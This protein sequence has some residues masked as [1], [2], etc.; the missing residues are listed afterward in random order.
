MNTL[1]H[2]NSHRLSQTAVLAPLLWFA[3]GIAIGFFF[4]PFNDSEPA[5][6]QTPPSQ[7]TATPAKSANPSSV[8]VP[9][10]L[11]VIDQLRALT[12]GGKRFDFAEALLLV[13]Q[14]PA[15]DCKTALALLRSAHGEFQ[16]P[17]FDALARRWADLDPYEAFS[18][19]ERERNN[20]IRNRLG[21]A[22]GAVLAERDP[23]AALDRIT[24]ARG[25]W[26]REK[27]AEWI[28]PAMAKTD[29][30][31]AAAYL[32]SN[33]LLT[34]HEHIYRDLAQAYGRSSP[35]GAII[36]AESLS[37]ERLRDQCTQKAWHGWL[38]TDPATFAVEINGW[39]NSVKRAQIAPLVSRHWSRAD[40]F[41]ALAW[42]ETVTD[43]RAREEASG[44]FEL[45]LQKIG[46]DGARKILGTIPSEN[47][48]IH[49]GRVTA[50]QLARDSV[51]EA[52]KWIDTLPEGRARTH[53]LEPVLNEW[54]QTD[55]AAAAQYLV[56]A[57]EMKD[58]TEL[59]RKTISHWTDVEP[60]TA[61]AY[62]EQLPP[63]RNRDFAVGIAIN[64]MVEQ[65]PQKAMDLLKTL[66]D[67]QVIG[68]A[69]Q[70]MIGTLVKTDPPAALAIA[71][72]LPPEAQKDAYHTLVRGWG[73][74]NA[75]AAGEWINTLP[76]GTGR[77]S[78]IKAYVSVIDGMD[79]ALATQWAHTIADPIERAESTLRTF[80]RWM[81]AD[82]TAAGAWVQQAEIPEGFRPFY[83]RMLNDKEYWKKMDD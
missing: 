20:D 54:A 45:D 23:Q 69:A 66:E 21:Y 34:R 77:D 44:A 15:A 37:S 71:A 3:A 83:D 59:F 67:P 52:L 5:P 29:P 56:N 4:R 13:R 38:Q 28:L 42:I 27:S 64:A 17:L 41:A 58:Q 7:L 32:A 10:T 14:L 11:P 62:V 73:F 36:W 43:P 76:A 35:R 75:K 50:E 24:K 31:R 40:P 12:S 49:L 16:Q 18:A 2:A 19:A 60:D 30:A 65:Q 33:K 51:T 72:Q 46:L 57:P 8:E 79:P 63:S 48:R 39:T 1:P 53:A 80:H 25:N 82:K 22:A 81:A 26:N 61:L 55:P 47:A 70:S 68:Q 9:P 74:E 78:A 6:I